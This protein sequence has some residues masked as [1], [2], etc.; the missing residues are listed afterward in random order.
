MAYSP[1]ATHWHLTGGQNAPTMH[2]LMTEKARIEVYLSE[3]AKATVQQRAREKGLSASAW[4]RWLILTA[5]T[6]REVKDA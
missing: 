1:I 5:L 2:L 3:S 4:V 6:G